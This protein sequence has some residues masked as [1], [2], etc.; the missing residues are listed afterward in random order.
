MLALSKQ[1]VARGDSLNGLFP[2]ISFGAEYSRSTKLLNNADTFYARP[3]PTTNFSSGFSIQIP[4]FDLGMRAKARG[5]TADALRA[6]VEV[7]QAER[8]NEIQ[9]AELT[10]SLRELGALA[11]IA[12]LKQQIADAQVKAVEAQMELGNGSGSG[13]G[14]QSQLTPKAEQLA[15]I[16]ERQ[17]FTDALDARF[18]LSKTRL[19]LLRALGH[20]EDWLHEL[21]AK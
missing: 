2:Q 13:P 21:H 11:E 6:T 3:I 17:K 7:E 15:R 19:T 8:Q 1:K 5:S 10:S 4:L 12:G 20:M 16:D 9:I 18:D 14:A